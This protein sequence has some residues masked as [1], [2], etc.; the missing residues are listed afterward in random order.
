MIEIEVS[1]DTTEGLKILKDCF[2]DRR[3]RGS[4]SD[5]SGGIYA[6]EKRT[7]LKSSGG[8]PET[9]SFVIKVRNIAFPSASKA[10]SSWLYDKLKSRKIS[11]F[12]LEGSNI[13][14]DKE[15]I[16]K[17]IEEIIQKKRK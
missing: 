2:G 11:D 1:A 3:K 15:K 10:I 4:R 13:E 5:I 8:G 7:T 12:E 9:I 14:I 16:E 17:R 6:E